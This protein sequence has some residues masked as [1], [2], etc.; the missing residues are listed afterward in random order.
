[1]LRDAG[2]RIVR[3]ARRKW[4]VLLA[5]AVLWVG[6]L[7]LVTTKPEAARIAG[8]HGV[9]LMY[10]YLPAWMP[11]ILLLCWYAGDRDG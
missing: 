10:F 7:Y 9:M 5:L 6:G 2:A 11:G 1:M 8:G 3:G 4:K